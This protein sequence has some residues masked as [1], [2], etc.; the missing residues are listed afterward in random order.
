MNNEPEVLSSDVPE[1]AQTKA[2]SQKRLMWVSIILL[3]ALSI[4]WI[5]FTPSGLLGKAD[6]VGYAVCHRIAIRSF[7]FP[8]GVQLPLC[9]RCTGTFLGVSIGLLAPGLLFRRRHAALFPPI[10]VLAILITFSV[11]WA[12]DGLNSY[13]FLLGPTV[14][15]LYTPHNLLRLATGLGQGIT[16]GSLLLP[17]F[18]SMLWADAKAERTLNSIWELLILIGIGVVLFGMILSGLAIFLYPL[19]ILSSLGVLL[20]LSAICTVTA[21]AFTGRENT[22][23]TLADALPIILL[24]T[25]MSL[26][27]LGVIDLARFAMTGTWDSFISPPV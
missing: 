26:A 8:D 1:Q 17:V 24:G 18:N 23:L 13:T 11:V 4:A 19:A 2:I 15:H 14:P 16:M 12:F 22:A 10:G 6:A 20:V 3:L 9:A 21:A 27:M 5:L 7:A 25:A